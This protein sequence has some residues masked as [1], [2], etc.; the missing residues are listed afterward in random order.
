MIGRA[1]YPFSFP[2]YDE[3]TKTSIEL[4]SLLIHPI[5]TVVIVPTTIIENM[6]RL[7][8]ILRS[9]ASKENICSVHTMDGTRT[10][11]KR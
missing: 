5:S 1:S 11:M 7:D 10:L 2:I 8:K 9:K 6:T 3:A 4:S